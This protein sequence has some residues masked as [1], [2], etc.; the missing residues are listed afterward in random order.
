MIPLVLQVPGWQCR[1]GMALHCAQPRIII[2]R[3]GAHD[4]PDGVK[5]VFHGKDEEQ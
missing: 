4:F 2:S 3:S 1:A 5:P